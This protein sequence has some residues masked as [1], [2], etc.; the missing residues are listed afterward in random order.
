VA[1]VLSLLAVG[2]A[3]GLSV[4]VAGDAGEVNC[5]NQSFTGFHSFL[6]D[7]RGYEM[8]TP[9]YKAGSRVNAALNPAAI[10]PDGARVIANSY[11]GFAGAENN[12]LNGFSNGGALYEFER[13]GVGWHTKSLSPSGKLVSHSSYVAASSDLGRTLWQLIETP[14]VGLPESLP[15]KELLNG[16][17]RYELAISSTQSP[18]S[19]F[20]VVGPED[21]PAETIDRRNF[22]FA[23]ASRD[24]SH[25][26]Y[27]ISENEDKALWPGDTTHEQ[28]PSL[29]EYVG[30]E[31]KEPVLV[32]VRNRQKLE[33]SPVNNGADLV[34]DCGTELGGAGKKYN[35]ISADGR[36]VIFT[37]LECGSSPLVN[38]LDARIGEEA[39]VAI[40]EPNRP[41]AQGAGTGPQECGATCEAAAPREATFEGASEDGS[42]VFF[43]TDQSLLNEDEGGEGTGNDLYEAELEGAR[44]KTLVEVSNDPNVGEAAEVQGV[45]RIAADGNRVYFVARGVLTSSP[46]KENV[47]P[48]SGANNLYVYDTVTRAT[49]FVS[50][51]ATGDK[52]DW[53]ATDSNRPVQVTTNGD[54][55]IFMSR[56]KVTGAE[57]TSTAAQLFEYDAIAQKLVR[58]SIG[59]QSVSGYICS[60]TGELETGY[61]CNGNTSESALSPKITS[62]GYSAEDLPT[63]SSSTLSLTGDGR[64]FFSSLNALTPLARD[65][66]KNIYEYRAGD[67]YLVAPGE[68]PTLEYGA[69]QEGIDENGRLI[70]TDVSGSDLFFGAV[71][72]LVGQDTDTQADLYDAR[73][74]GGF[75]GVVTVGGCET[76]C[77]G[78]NYVVPNLL[79]AT[80]ATTYAETVVPHSAGKTKVKARTPSREKM[81]LTT[82][83]LCQRR[84]RRERRRCEVQ[85]HK[86]Y[87]AKGNVKRSS[88][89][90]K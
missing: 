1:T 9:S 22:Q 61:N 90:P 23:G 8:V 35:A 85:A 60:Q 30:T 56:A 52:A 73:A 54:F 28:D 16:L 32:G 63:E 29:Y 72:Q 5:A 70:S 48:T 50:T 66:G 12:E 26:V 65:G 77:Q 64:V 47:S 15:E 6:A 82:L 7:C 86:R 80:S 45:A 88:Q 83:K 33:G 62:V 81:L 78:A 10:S 49:T 34:S 75:P 43:R 2:L 18:E 42:K 79:A 24:L 59:Q 37:A 67:V 41:L 58:V 44:L 14:P 68:D 53:R 4:S 74:N 3:V 21:S 38:E 27:S 51:L 89:R 31:R 69:F 46:N 55:A 25:I 84:P 20:E 17:T 13:S 76:S 57:D 11:G 71:G 39:T 87:K 19:G 36:V 40:S